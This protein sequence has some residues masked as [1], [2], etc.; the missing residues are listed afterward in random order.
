MTTGSRGTSLLANSVIDGGQGA[1]GRTW[2]PARP[3][4]TW[5]ARSTA[6]AGSA[7]GRCRPATRPSPATP[8]DHPLLLRLRR[9]AGGAGRHRQDHPHHRRPRRRPD[10]EPDPLRGAD[11]GLPAHGA[12]LRPD[13]G[14]PLQGRLP[15]LAPHVR[16]GHHQGQGH[17]AHRDHRR[18]G[19]GRGR[20]LRRQGR[21]RDR[22]GADRRRG[23]QRPLR[24]RRR[25]PHQA[26]P[27]G[28]EGPGQE[29]Q[30]RP[31]R[32]HHA[33]TTG[34][35]TDKESERCPTSTRAWPSWPPSTS[36]WRRRS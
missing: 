12:R 21:R 13:R 36:P 5:P 31:G 25:P 9:P 28:A 18:R 34:P 35:S 17:A 33:V 1:E 20:P 11:R 6:A 30:G 16:P 10:H 4:P 29:A 3:W 27:Q 14:V 8:V 15:G 2:P 22:P 24:A 32:L 23:R 7:T 26:S 19:A